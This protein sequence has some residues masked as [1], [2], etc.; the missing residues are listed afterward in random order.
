MEFLTEEK[1][2]HFRR[3]NN[4]PRPSIGVILFSNIVEN[5]LTLAFSY[6]FWRNLSH[7]SQA[8]SNRFVVVLNN[9][10]SGVNQ[11]P[12]QIAAS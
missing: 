10:V 1:N 8:R 12:W 2:P 9:K 11:G 6:S 4:A 3:F 5:D 7:S